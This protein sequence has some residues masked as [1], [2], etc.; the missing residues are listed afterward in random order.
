MHAFAQHVPEFLRLY[1]NIFSQQGLEK[2]ND[3]TTKHYQRATNQVYEALKQVLEKRNRIELL[4]DG[5]YQRTKRV[6]T[7]SIVNSLATTS[8]CAPPDP[9]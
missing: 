2:L 1:G 5:G 9:L 3:L 7:C 8:V 6:Q 4:E